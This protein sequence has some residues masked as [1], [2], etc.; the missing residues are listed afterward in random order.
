MFDKLR[1]KEHR[2]E[3]QP[4]FIPADLAEIGRQP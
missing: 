4:C 2:T 1:I 3:R